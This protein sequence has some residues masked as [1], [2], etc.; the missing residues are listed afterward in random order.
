M[1]KWLLFGAIIITSGIVCNLAWLVTQG[2]GL[3]DL[4]V[5]LTYTV[6][7]FFFTAILALMILV[8]AVLNTISNKRTDVAVN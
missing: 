2:A 7:L 6:L 3:I 1:W 5:Q 4:S 8:F